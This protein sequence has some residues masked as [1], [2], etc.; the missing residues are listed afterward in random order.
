MYAPH[1]YKEILVGLV[2]SHAYGLNHEGSDTDYRGV[3]VAPTKEVLGVFPVKDVV[4]L[5]EPYD[6]CEYELSKFVYLC[7]KVNPSIIEMLYLNDYVALTEEGQWL[8]DIR[9]SFLSTLVAKTFGGYAM[10]QMNRLMNRNDGS[11]SSDT[12]KRYSKHARHCFRLI[13]QGHELLTTGNLTV[14]LENPEEIFWIGEQKPEKLQ[15]LFLSEM[16]K[17]DNVKSVLPEHPDYSAVNEVLLRIR[18]KN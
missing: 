4:N 17:L 9:E 12:R 3:Y 1:N 7:L 13:L 8:I 15:E 18:E 2:G 11:F 10:S 16:S 14:R 6:I 5:N